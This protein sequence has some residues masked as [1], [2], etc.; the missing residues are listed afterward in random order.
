MYEI[1]CLNI[2]TI[3]PV[4]DLNQYHLLTSAQFNV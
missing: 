2:I 4:F 3:Y 1:K